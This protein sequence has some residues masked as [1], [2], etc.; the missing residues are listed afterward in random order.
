MKRKIQ[1]QDTC[2]EQF[3]KLRQVSGLQQ[4]Q[5]REIVNLLRE[6][7]QEQ[8]STCRKPAQKYP[9]ALAVEAELRVPHDGAV[10]A[11]VAANSFPALVQAKVTACPLFS[12]LLSRALTKHHN[13]LTLLFYADEANPGNILAPRAP[14]KANLCY[15]TFL[16]LE[17]LF[18]ESLWLTL[19]VIL[20]NEAAEIHAG[21]ATVVRL[22]LE[23][24]RE[25]T[26]LGFPLDIAGDMHMVFVDRVVVLADHEGLRSITGAKGASGL[27]PC[28]LCSN[29]LNF[30]RQA[31]NHVSMAEAEVDTFVLQTQDGVLAVYEHLRRCVNASQL[32]SAETLLGWTK[33][34]LEQSFLMSPILREWADH[35]SIY[36]DAMHQYWSNGLISQE[37][38]LWHGQLVQQNIGV[39]PLQRWVALHW[40]SLDGTGSPQSVVTKKM[41]R[42]GADYRG[43][44]DDCLIALP[45]CAAFAQEILGDVAA[46]SPFNA[47]LLALRDVTEKLLRSKNNVSEAQGLDDLQKK[48]MHL[49]HEAYGTHVTRPKMHY[50]RHLPQ[51]IARHQRLVDA[52]TCERKH[53]TF[54]STVAPTRK[55]LKDFSRSVLREL[56]EI[57]LNQTLPVEAFEGRFIGKKQTRPDVAKKCNLPD[58]TP[59]FKG[60]EVSCVSYLR[61][62]FLLTQKLACSC[63]GAVAWQKEK[64]LLVE[65]LTKEREMFTP[66]QTWTKPNGSK[67]S[68]LPLSSLR[69][70]EKAKI[71][72]ENT[73]TICLLR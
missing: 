28:C 67:L 70:A 2:A 65:Q 68:L 66:L 60:L 48:H 3:E 27:K 46:M 24:I 53:R 13:T 43:D 51:Q 18:K 6:E 73:R 34:T 45:L 39:A 62:D 22:L 44:A 38:G 25:D 33:S 54:K 61:G 56:T 59:I 47:S 11:Q 57:D 36:Y 4:R 7:S 16:E 71:L 52:F 63:C 41:W 21:Y 5:R 26:K 17:I 37:L 10:S 29:V 58:D 64:F 20:A 14:R 8:A 35:S 55:K 1:Q 32:K 9:A 15:G 49:F 30:E 40:K 23:Q 12:K 50:S 72:R 42:T 69:G 31:R 19:S